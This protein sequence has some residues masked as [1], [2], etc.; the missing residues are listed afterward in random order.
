MTHNS[1][2]YSASEKSAFNLMAL[3]VYLGLFYQ[4]FQTYVGSWSIPIFFGS[5]FLGIFGIIRILMIGRNRSDIYI[6][7]FLLLIFYFIVLGFVTGRKSDFAIALSQDLRYV[8]YFLMGAVFSLN[9]RYMAMFHKIMVRIGYVAIILGVYAI[10]HFSVSSIALRE[11]VWTDNYFFWWASSSAFAYLGA[12]ALVKRKDMIVGL[13]TLAVFFI[14][15]SMFLKRSAFLDVIV[16]VSLVA[17]LNSNK[18]IR[19]I[20]F[21]AVASIVFIV[22]LQHFAPEYYAVTSEAMFNR[23]DQIDDVSEVDRNIEAQLFFDRSSTIQLILGYGIFN[24]P[25]SILIERPLN[26]LHSG[27]ANIIFKGGIFYVFWYIWI[28]AKVFKGL[29]GIRKKDGLYMVCSIVALS[30]LVSLLFEG[31][32]TYSIS[33]FCISAPIFYAARNS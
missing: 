2:E 12:Y 4:C 18:P 1:Y 25:W 6:L 3:S 8:M 31:G 27:W 19:N 23:F 10:L 28:Y 17:L 26:A 24:Y 21:L 7:T 32:W 29:L 33:P 9:E 11:S 15:G 16:I 5:L 14:L 13:G 20:L 22:L 30:A